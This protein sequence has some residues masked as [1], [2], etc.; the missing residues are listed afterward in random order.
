MALSPGLVLPSSPSTPGLSPS[1]N[2]A[3]PA[4]GNP[5]G[6]LAVVT[7][8]WRGGNAKLLGVTQLDEKTVISGYS[9]LTQLLPHLGHDDVYRKFD[10]GKGWHTG[11]N[12][13]LTGNVIPEFLDPANPQQHMKSFR[14]VEQRGPALTHFVGM[15]G[16]ED[17]R[18]L[19]AASLPRSDP[20]AGIFG[21]NEV[22][23][24]ADVTDGTSQTILLIG[25]GRVMGPWVEGGGATIRGAREPY[26]D[27]ISGFSSASM[28]GGGAIAAMADGSV[29]RIS[30]D[31]DPAVFRAL[32]TMHGAETID[33]KVLDAKQEGK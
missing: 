12:L 21:Y 4:S 23:K 2:G 3:L 5:G 26:F 11:A 28:N 6:R 9:W 30:K 22:A 24:P 25:S 20:R 15:S 29:R 14:F 27:E 1:A 7:N 13:Q 10:F 19:V 18:N 16:V 17:K 31:I 32:C 33:L 8:Q